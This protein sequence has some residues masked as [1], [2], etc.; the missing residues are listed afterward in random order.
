[1]LDN[2]LSSGPIGAAKRVHAEAHS[3]QRHAGAEGV[4]STNKFKATGIS[5]YAPQ[6]SNIVIPAK[7]GTHGPIF[8]RMT[9]F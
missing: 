5:V 3:P 7:A 8:P 1:M 9:R 4:Q 2:V 6:N